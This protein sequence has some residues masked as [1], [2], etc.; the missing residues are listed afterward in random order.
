MLCSAEPEKKPN[1]NKL[2]ST[3]LAKTQIGGALL[4]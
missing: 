2:C 3:E 1:L 4:D